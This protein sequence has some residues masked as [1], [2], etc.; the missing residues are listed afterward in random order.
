[1]TLGQVEDVESTPTISEGVRNISIRSCPSDDTSSLTGG[2]KPGIKDILVNNQMITD[3]LRSETGVKTGKH[4]RVR[5]TI[6]KKGPSVDKKKKKKRPSSEGDE[7]KMENPNNYVYGR[8]RKLVKAVT[9]AQLT[10]SMEFTLDAT[11]DAIK[12]MVLENVLKDRGVVDV[13]DVPQITCR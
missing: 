10:G 9:P 6:P 11:P 7:G 5:S 12:W 3:W 8:I 4:K 2:D 1:M 13:K